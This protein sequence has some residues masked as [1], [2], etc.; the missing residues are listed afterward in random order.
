MPRNGRYATVSSFF[1]A[2]WESQDSEVMG[3]KVRRGLELHPGG[4][5]T[6][7]GLS[8]E[9]QGSVCREVGNKDALGSLNGSSRMKLL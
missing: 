5:L 3:V 9:P 6:S 2:L 4:L 7:V 8:P 1:S